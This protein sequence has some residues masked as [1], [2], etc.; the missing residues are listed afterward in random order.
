MT[1]HGSVG[2]IGKHDF[3]PKKAQTVGS[4]S[5]VIFVESAR[6]K[7]WYLGALQHLQILRSQGSVDPGNVECADDPLYTERVNVL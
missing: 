3:I 5:L 4:V 7:V 6:H 1:Y 2:S